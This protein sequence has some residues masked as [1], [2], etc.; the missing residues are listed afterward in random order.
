VPA[1]LA[2]GSLAG[3]F[4]LLLAGGDKL[5]AWYRHNQRSRSS[6]TIH[7]SFWPIKAAGECLIGGLAALG[8]TVHQLGSGSP[9]V[10]NLSYVAIGSTYAFL[11]AFSA[12]RG[13]TRPGALCGCSILLEVPLRNPWSW[14]TLRATIIAACATAYLV[15]SSVAGTVPATPLTIMWVCLAA[16]AIALVAYVYPYVQVPQSRLSGVPSGE[17]PT[18]R[19][20]A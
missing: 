14:V 6:Y 20:W 7:R 13:K 11:A 1:I 16:L 10:G 12:F 17:R 19:S 8:L 15:T 4:L 3:G 5:R 2:A 18:Q 9:V